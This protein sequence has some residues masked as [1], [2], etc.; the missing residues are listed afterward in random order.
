MMYL[1]V[2]F[3]HITWAQITLRRKKQKATINNFSMNQCSAEQPPRKK[4]IT[5]LVKKIKMKNKTTNLPEQHRKGKKTKRSD[6]QP[7]DKQKTTINLW[8]TKKQNG[9]QKTTI[10]FAIN[11]KKER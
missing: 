4:E 6:N 11:T 5:L 9:K 7:S 3:H 1:T 10:N 8:M 2:V